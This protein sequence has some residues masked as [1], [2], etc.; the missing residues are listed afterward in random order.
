LSQKVSLANVEWLACGSTPSIVEPAP[1][2]FMCAIY[3]RLRLMKPLL[4]ALLSLSI[5]P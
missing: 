2:A 1:D 5:S 4:L 3:R